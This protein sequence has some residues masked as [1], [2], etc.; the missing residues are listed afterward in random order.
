[1]T[2]PVGGASEVDLTQPVNHEEDEKA[3]WNKQNYRHSQNHLVQTFSNMCGVIVMLL[4]GFVLQKQEISS[5][6]EV[7]L[8]T[9]RALW[10]PYMG[11]VLWG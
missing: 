7:G 2:D 10:I 11:G 6:L 9:S 3:K 5:A 4:L 1:M 8:G